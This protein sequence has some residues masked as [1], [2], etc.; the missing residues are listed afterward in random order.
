MKSNAA[1]GLVALEFPH[2]RIVRPT[3]Y[4][5]DVNDERPQ[6]PVSSWNRGVPVGIL[7]G[8][9]QE[10]AVGLELIDEVRDFHAWIVSPVKCRPK[11]ISFL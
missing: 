1:T 8:C 3:V 2:N 5:T 11:P 7:D 9:N 6:V 10:R 4:C